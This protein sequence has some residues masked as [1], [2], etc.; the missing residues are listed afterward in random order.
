[1]MPYYEI[2]FFVLLL[3]QDEIKGVVV[4]SFCFVMALSNNYFTPIL[5][6]HESINYFESFLIVDFVFFVFSFFIIYSTLGWIIMIT[7]FFSIILNMLALIVP[8]GDYYNWYMKVYPFL[9]VVLFEVLVYICIT[10][11]KI[12]PW[13]RDNLK[14]KLK[15]V[16]TC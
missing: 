7:M 13:L 2:L 6:M 16:N 9:N 5:E 8:A 15:R 4:T 10:K 3:L 11:S 12:Y 1:M 14:D